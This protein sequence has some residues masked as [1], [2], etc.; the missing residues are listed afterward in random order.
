[1]GNIRAFSK[2]PEEAVLEGLRI[3]A[4]Q[5]ADDPLWAAFAHILEGDMEAA[6]QILETFKA[7][8][9]SNETVSGSTKIRSIK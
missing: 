7:N 1:M 5:K 4:H 9:V 2:D 3:E 6:D 8:P